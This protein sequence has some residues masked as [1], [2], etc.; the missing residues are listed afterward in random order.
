V[1]CTF[2]ANQASPAAHAQPGPP[3]AAAAGASLGCA[4]APAAPATA[5]VTAAG[6]ALGPAEYVKLNLVPE[7]Q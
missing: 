4:A 7:S 5:P 3:L 2:I 1:V 6:A